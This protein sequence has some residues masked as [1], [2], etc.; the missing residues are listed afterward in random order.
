M[1][2]DI[3]Q[4]DL[5]G[6]KGG[7]Y[8]GTSAATPVS[9]EAAAV[10]AVGLAHRVRWTGVWIGLLLVL[11]IELTL[12]ALVVWIA[13][14][15]YGTRLAEVAGIIGFWSALFAVVGVFIGSLVAARLA[16]TTQ[17]ASG[18]W[19]GIAVWGLAMLGGTVLR[20]IGS[21]GRFGYLGT[22]M[23]RVPPAFAP[24]TSPPPAATADVTRALMVTAAWFVIGSVVAFIA[25]L[26]GGAAG[27]RHTPK[28]ATS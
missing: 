24:T 19:H 5:A 15:T 21:I 17:T 25:A 3:S 26:L 13:A 7:T 20:S 8:V 1:P 27:V 10:E 2:D 23:G 4:G 9:A 14:P 28:Q 12:T 11:P 6:R 22:L 18:L 16:D